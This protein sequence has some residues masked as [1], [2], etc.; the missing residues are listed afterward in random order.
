WLGRLAAS[1]RAG[2]ALDPAD[3][4][5]LAAAIE[6]FLAGADFEQAL[7]FDHGWRNRLRYEQRDKLVREAAA[8]L[9]PRVNSWAQARR[10]STALARY[11]SCGWLHDRLAPECPRP[12]HQ[13]EARFFAILRLIDSNL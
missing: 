1:L 7:G 2:Q 5:V 12:D 3:A 6:R 8:Q 9:S 4:A 13:I 10:F 11:R